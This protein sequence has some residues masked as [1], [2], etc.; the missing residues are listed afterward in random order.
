MG[1]PFRSVSLLEKYESSMYVPLKLINRKGAL[2]RGP[3]LTHV[4]PGQFSKNAQRVRYGTAVN[5]LFTYPLGKTLTTRK[6]YDRTRCIHV[7]FGKKRS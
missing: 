7:P 4:P 1:A 3:L 6:E 2:L 5:D